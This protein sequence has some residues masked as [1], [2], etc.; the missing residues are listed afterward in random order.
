[1]RQY[2]LNPKVSVILPVYNGAGTVDAAIRSILGQTFEDLELLVVNDGSTDNTRM[3]VDAFKDPRIRTFHLLKNVG[4]S[5]ARNLGFAKAQSPYIAMIDAD[6]LAYP[7]RIE[8]QF[9][10]MEQHTYIGLCG[11]W[12]QVEDEKGYRIEWRQPLTNERIRRSIV[13][14]NTFIH[15]TVLVRKSVLE[16]LGGFDKQF[17]PAEDYDLYLRIT[18][19]YTVANL[20]CV[21]ASYRAHSSISYRLKEQWA[22]L[23]VRWNAIRKYG[24]PFS[25]SIYLLT[26][27]LGLLVPMRFKVLLKTHSIPS[28]P[29]VC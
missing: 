10:F 19:Q 26:P 21:L 7:D 14:S 25:Q 12:A 13:R 15:C 17:E 4:R 24:Y 5:E 28:S 16:K 6:D 20:P 3:V 18:S 11:A 27:L 23:P 1:M 2:G 9:K 29:D 8:R 22:K